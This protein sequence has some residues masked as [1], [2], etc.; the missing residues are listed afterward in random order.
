MSKGIGGMHTEAVDLGAV[1]WDKSRQGVWVGGLVFLPR[2]VVV[3]AFQE[4]AG[5]EEMKG[6]TDG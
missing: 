1:K 3:K 4:V 2:N 5:H 6:E